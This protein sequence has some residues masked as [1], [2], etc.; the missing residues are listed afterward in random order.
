MKKSLFQKILFCFLILSVLVTSASCSREKKTETAPITGENVSATQEDSAEPWDIIGKV[1]IFCATRETGELTKPGESN[2]LEIESKEDLAPY[3]E[4]FDELSDEKEKS[5]L[6][7]AG[8]RCIFMEVVQPR[9]G[10]TYFCNSVNRY[11][12]VIEICLVEGEEAEAL[13][14]QYFLFCFPSDVY[15]LEDIRV[16]FV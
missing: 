4:L 14:H 10:F 3:R 11:N 9:E 12:G 16:L 15:N 1:E 8:G 7:D 5:I 2:I 13:K 6:E